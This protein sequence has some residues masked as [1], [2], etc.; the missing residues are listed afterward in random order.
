MV[1]IAFTDNLKKHIDCPASQ[2]D[3]ATVREALNAVFAANPSLR[4]YILD[5]QSRL[6][7]HVTIF[8]NGAMIADRTTLDIPVSA[9]DEVYVFQAL[10]GG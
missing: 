8:H 1:R 2:V 6:R 9:V 10:S 3:G 4:A 7:K 5:D